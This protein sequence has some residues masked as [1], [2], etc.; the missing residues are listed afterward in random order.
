M[1]EK[2]RNEILSRA[3]Y[4]NEV[5]NREG[6]NTIL[7]DELREVIHEYG[8]W[9]ILCWIEGFAKVQALTDLAK[10]FGK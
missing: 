8:V 6:S 10:R 3:Q 4:W 1:N 2:Q 7:I 5:H 9:T